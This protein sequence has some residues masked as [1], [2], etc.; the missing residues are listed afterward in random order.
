MHQCRHGHTWYSPYAM[1]AL[2]VGPEI[3]TKTAVGELQIKKVWIPFFSE[4]LLSK[5]SSGAA[6]GSKWLRVS[7]VISSVRRWGCTGVARRSECFS[8]DL[9]VNAT[10]FHDHCVRRSS[11]NVQVEET[12]FECASNFI[13]T[14]HDVALPH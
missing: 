10:P 12:W 5:W 9:H 13:A 4:R 8:S 7:L 3:W 6:L 11:S 14:E 1:P 2:L